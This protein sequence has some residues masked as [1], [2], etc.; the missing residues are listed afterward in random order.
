[1]TTLQPGDEAPDLEL[2]D[3]TGQPV[4][5][6]DYRDKKAVVLAFIPF[7]FT[8]TC[9]SEACGIRDRLESFRNDD[10][11]TLVV[12]V[13]SPPTHRA[14]AEQK[15]F[16]FPV[17]ADFWPHGDVARRY[18]VFNEHVGAADRGTFVIDR[19]GR[20][21][22]AEH[23]ELGEHRDPERWQEALREIGALD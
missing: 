8:R 19:S 20:I 4:R 9:D 14:W 7:P 10:V 13:A 3:Q 12:T 1:M 6:S 5:L 15:G 23:N 11:E 21:V 22:F 17:L 18:G 2:R 16:E